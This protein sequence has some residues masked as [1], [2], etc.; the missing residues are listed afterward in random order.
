VSISVILAV[1]GG[2]SAAQSAV[3]Q[4]NDVVRAKSELSSALSDAAVIKAAASQHIAEAST[5]LTA[6]DRVLASSHGR[7]LE[8]TTRAALA[9]RIRRAEQV[10]AAARIELANLTPADLGTVYKKGSP[11]GLQEA[12]SDVQHAKLTAIRGIAGSVTD[13]VDAQS[14]VA[15]AVTSW[16]AHRNAAAAAKVRASAHVEHVWAAGFQTQVNA[17]RGSVVLTKQ[18]GVPTIG[19]RW[20]CG[21]SQF[22]KQGQYVRLTG[23]MSGLYRVGR[24]AAVLDASVNTSLDVPRGY[25]LLYQTCRNDNS[26]TMTF[27]VLTK[28]AD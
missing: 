9:D 16:N 26:H 25:Q 12:A 21:G 6:A 13:V 20:D 11:E 7:T 15:A 8:E 23:L 14:K 4:T 24:V 1:V 22:A 18:Y 10:L 3:A 2:L 5:K 27:T 28:V 17:C 19:E